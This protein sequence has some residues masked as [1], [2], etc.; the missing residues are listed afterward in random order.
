MH[1]SRRLRV[2]TTV[3]FLG[4]AAG[5]PG[6][7]YDAY[8]P[9]PA[10]VGHPAYYY[11]YYYY[12]GASVYFNLYSGYYYYRSNNVWIRARALPS[13]IYLGPRVSLR[14]WSDRPYTYYNVHRERYRPGPSYRPSP[15][16][17]HG[18]RR[19]DADRHQQYLKR[20]H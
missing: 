8:G 6:C 19:Y 14:I 9:G 16:R 17:D 2:L 12:P 18:E 10:A 4:L 11:D 13:Y 5:L 15:G 1:T 20:Y 3:L 7:V